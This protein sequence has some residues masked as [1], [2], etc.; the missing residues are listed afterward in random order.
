[1]YPAFE[2]RSTACHDGYRG[3]GSEHCGALRGAV[4]DRSVPI[5]FLTFVP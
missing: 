2:M 4:T 3:L 5:L 1:M